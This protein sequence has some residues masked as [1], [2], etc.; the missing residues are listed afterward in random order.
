MPP[1]HLPVVPSARP[2]AYWGAKYLSFRC[3]GC[4]N[5]C[6]DTIVP[7][8]GDDLRRLCEGT[9]LP[10]DRVV[11]FYAGDEF[12]DGGSGLVYVELDVGARTMGLRRRAAR[13]HGEATDVCRFFRDGRC[14]VYEHRPVTCRLWP[15]SL[16]LDGRGRP[17][18]LALN[19]AVECP[20]ALDGQVDE[21]ALVADWRLDDEQDARWRRTARA[22]NLRHS[23]G[24]AAEFLAFAGLAA[25]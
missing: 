10:A 17:T 8:T 1:R 4:G 2:R 6:T 7:I 23:G 18:R 22:W 5:C 12:D 24:T 19:D 21:A 25:A 9:G 20:Y 11:S 3:T 15:F 13:A 14:S 16:T